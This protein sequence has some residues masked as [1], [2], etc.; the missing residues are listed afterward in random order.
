MA[1]S[2]GSI[3]ISVRLKYFTMQVRNSPSNS[4]VKKINI[5]QPK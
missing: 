1:M 5:T 3:I 4:T 2:N